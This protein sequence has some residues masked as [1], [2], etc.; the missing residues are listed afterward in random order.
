MVIERK[1]YGSLDIAKFVMA[2]LILVGHIANEWAHTGGIWHYILACDF[3]VPS[4]FAI[5]GFLF[6]NKLKV[7]DGE[8]EFRIIKNGH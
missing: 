8:R 2:I 3:T 4:F 7:M 1:V 6:F 5:S